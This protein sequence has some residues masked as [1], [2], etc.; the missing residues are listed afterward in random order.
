MKRKIADFLRDRERFGQG[1]A[2]RIETA[3][4][5]VVE[6]FAAAG[7]RPDDDEAARRLQR[8]GRVRTVDAHRKL[9]PER[10]SGTVELASPRP[11]TTLRRLI[12]FAR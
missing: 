5:D 10:A 11:S 6:R 4:D 2:R 12:S 8:D 3:A 1:Q 9:G 7:G